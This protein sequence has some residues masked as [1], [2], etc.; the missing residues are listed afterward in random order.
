MLWDAL[1]QESYRS[2]PSLQSTQQCCCRLQH[3]LYGLACKQWPS[4]ALSEGWDEPRHA[5][6]PPNEIMHNSCCSKL[7]V[8]YGCTCCLCH[9]KKA[10]SIKAWNKERSEVVARVP[11]ALRGQVK[12]FELG[13]GQQPFGLY[14]PQLCQPVFFQVLLNTYFVRHGTLT[15][16]V[17][18]IAF[19]SWDVICLYMF[20][21]LP[22]MGGAQQQLHSTII[23][24]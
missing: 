18:C 3:S 24:D 22:L 9:Q 13:D 21:R 8:V 7:L 16:M 11:Q 15:S 10:H 20:I 5:N 1:L 6:V 2:M 19:W 14:S 17:A 23:C 12:G 4:Y